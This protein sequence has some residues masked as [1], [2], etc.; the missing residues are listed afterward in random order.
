VEARPVLVR[1]AVAQM[2]TVDGPMRSWAASAAVMTPFC[3]YTG[4]QFSYT[5]SR[6]R[7][8]ESFGATATDQ[9]LTVV[10][11]INEATNRA[12]LCSGLDGSSRPNSL[13]ANIYRCGIMPFIHPVFLDD[14]LRL[15]TVRI[16]DLIPNE[17]PFQNFR[18]CSLNPEALT[19]TRYKYR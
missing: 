12:S 14:L 8:L 3:A 2:V 18:T 1:V 4:S 5:F 11:A 19:S 15:S 13:G 16:M 6:N 10:I 7:F 17:Y 9:R